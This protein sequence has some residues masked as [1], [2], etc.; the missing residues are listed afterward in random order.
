MPS[1]KGNVYK[2]QFQDHKVQERGRALEQRVSA[3]IIDTEG[4][5]KADHTDS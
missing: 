5:G 2:T 4:L 3:L 1:D